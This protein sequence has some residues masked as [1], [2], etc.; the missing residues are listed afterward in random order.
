M[1]ITPKGESYG[2]TK[3]NNIN[4]IEINDSSTSYLYGLKVMF[5]PPFL[6]ATGEIEQATEGVSSRT[7]KI[8]LNF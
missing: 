6:S 1:K 8:N 4:D 5:M 2:F 3:K 7:L